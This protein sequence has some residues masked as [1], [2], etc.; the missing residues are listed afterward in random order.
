MGGDRCLSAELVTVAPGYALQ[1][2]GAAN[3]KAL[4]TT[5]DG[6][7]GRD[8][9]A[10]GNSDGRLGFSF[11][12]VG[13]DCVADQ[14]SGLTWAMPTA[15]SGPT[16]RDTLLAHAEA[17]AHLSVVN[18]ARRCGFSD[19]R[20]PSASEL[21]GLVDYSVPFG[22]P[23]IDALWF[24]LVRAQTY[25]A[26]E[27]ARSPRGEHH[28]VHLFIGEASHGDEVLQA[29]T[30]QYGRAR[31]LPVRGAAAAEGT[32]W[33]P[34]IDASGQAWR[35]PNLKELDSLVG[36]R[37]YKPAIDPEAFPGTP[38]VCFH[39]ST[40]WID[41]TLPPPVFNIE[42]KTMGVSFEDGFV[43]RAGGLPCLLRLVRSASP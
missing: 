3:A 27:T 40:P 37:R 2:C 12:A 7:L 29:T 33:A 28:H 21:L 10:P 32:R 41:N 20:L 30:G 14:V 35:L 17:T 11:A 38:S 9:T 23:T 19:W 18:A 36:R 5:Q 25:W 26:G 1:D 43:F 16:G 4:S 6:M 13:T 39:S 22:R 31:L 34:L 8:V 42:A 24:P 15:D